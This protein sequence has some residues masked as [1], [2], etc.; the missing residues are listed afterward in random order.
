MCGSFHRRIFTTHYNTVGWG[1]W[2]CDYYN[3]GIIPHVTY[4]S[5]HILYQPDDIDTNTAQ[6][7]IQLS[8]FSTVN[9]CNYTSA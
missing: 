6:L 5:T 3:K 4:N 9:W 8:G 1:L 7:N 2:V